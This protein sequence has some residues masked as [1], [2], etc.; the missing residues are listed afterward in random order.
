MYK[1]ETETNTKK[2]IIN[3]ILLISLASFDVETF[4]MFNMALPITCPLSNY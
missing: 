2:V 3:G 1:N 4:G